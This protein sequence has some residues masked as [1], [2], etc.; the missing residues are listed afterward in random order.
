MRI[1][2]M[3]SPQFAVASLDIL[4]S[5]GYNIVGVITAPDR[6][7]GRG[8]KLRPSAVKQY[9]RE[10]G[11]RILQPTNLKSPD[12][13]EELGSLR[14]DLQIVVAFRMLPESVWDMPPVGTV[15][16]HASLLPQYRGAA[17]INWVLINGETQTGVTTFF[18]EHLIDT[19]D[20]L[21]QRPVAIAEGET[22][23]SLHDKLMVEGAELVLETVRGIENGSLQPIPQET[24]GE[25]KKAPKIFREDCRIDW[26]LPARKVY[27]FIRGLSP[28]PAA[29]TELHGKQLKIFS[30]DCRETEHD[31]EPGTFISDGNSYIHVYS[32]DGYLS[33]VEIQLEGK[34]RMSVADF[35]NGYNWED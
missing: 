16:L 23:G 11:L 34:R 1:V 35:L 22:A 25:L 30:A 29:F 9:A 33:L 26:A 19:G 28:Y 10:K 17:P 6:P 2:F 27:D 7:A 24:D 32:P 21:L 13:L 31:V 15:N 12:F 3:G 8:R 14:A 5:N 20:L 4:V 18:I